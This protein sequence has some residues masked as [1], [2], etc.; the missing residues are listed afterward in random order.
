MDDPWDLPD[1]M[2]VLSDEEDLRALGTSLIGLHSVPWYAIPV[3][4]PRPQERGI[5]NT[6][7]LAK[8][9]YYTVNY[10]LVARTIHLP[11]SP[12]Y[13]GIVFKQCHSY[14]WTCS[15]P[16]FHQPF[17]KL[18]KHSTACQY[19][20]SY[21]GRRSWYQHIVLSVAFYFGRRIPT[22]TFS[23]PLWAGLL[24]KCKMRT[25]RISTTKRTRRV[26]TRY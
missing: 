3:I 17:Y 16:L 19:C 14:H 20:R 11:S 23:S 24:I 4:D 26:V 9:L 6:S 7:L 12:W 5:P 10:R 25:I 18:S 1:Q 15:K 8:L 22:T 21:R 2:P 13:T